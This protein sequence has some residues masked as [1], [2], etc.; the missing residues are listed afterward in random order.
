MDAYVMA[1][2]RSALGVAEGSRGL[3]QR[4]LIQ[5]AERDPRLLMGLARPVLPAVVGSLIDRATGRN[6]TT[7]TGGPANT[8]LSSPPGRL[9]PAAA[10]RRRARVEDVLSGVLGRDALS[11]GMGATPANPPPPAEGDL[12]AAALRRIAQAQARRRG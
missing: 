10:A 9:Q 4:L 7:G 5:W 1:K 8:A 2:V 12:H 6:A 3:A 11:F